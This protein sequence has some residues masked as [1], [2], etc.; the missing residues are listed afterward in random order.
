ML[1]KPFSTVMQV[2]LG[3][4]RV[5]PCPICQKEDTRLSAMNLAGRCYGSCGSVKLEKLYDLVLSPRAARREEVRAMTR[6]ANASRGLELVSRLHRGR[7]QAENAPRGG[8]RELPALSGVTK[9]CTFLG[10]QE[11]ILADARQILVESRESS[12][13]ATRLSWS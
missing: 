4:T 9:D 5:E 1:S 6:L 2:L 10:N 3:D 11:N 8:A 12:D 13:T 7:Q